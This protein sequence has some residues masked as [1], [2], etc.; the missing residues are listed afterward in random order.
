MTFATVCVALGKKK[1][2]LHGAHTQLR[3]NGPQPRKGRKDPLPWRAVGGDSA[4]APILLWLHRAHFS[5]CC[6]ALSALTGAAGDSAHVGGL[7]DG[8]GV[9]GGAWLLPLCVTTCQ[10]P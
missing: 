9:Y 8:P 4:H 6:N 5:S 7:W 1:K 2:G 3:C 10:L